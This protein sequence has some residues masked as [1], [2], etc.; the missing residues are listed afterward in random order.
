ME[1]FLTILGK[2]L[3][4]EYDTG[5]YSIKSSGKIDLSIASDG[6]KI[7]MTFNGVRPEVSVRFILRI[8]LPL[9]S[10][11]FHDGFAYVKPSGWN[12]ITINLKELINESK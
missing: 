10:I 2:I 7:V 1:K 11:T 12:A 9:E 5:K 8:K 6:D 4:G 3:S